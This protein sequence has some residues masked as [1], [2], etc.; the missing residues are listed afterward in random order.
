MILSITTD[1][2]PVTFGLLVLPEVSRVSDT[3]LDRRPDFAVHMNI[4]W[5]CCSIQDPRFSR[6]SCDYRDGLEMDPS[7]LQVA[8]FKSSPLNSKQIEDRPRKSG[9]ILVKKSCIISITVLSI[10]LWITQK[11]MKHQSS[12]TNN[13]HEL[14]RLWYIQSASSCLTYFA[15][16]SEP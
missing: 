7:L 15:K 3:V 2:E 16:V 10:D 14:G 8:K 5:G 12:S 4:Y 9:D 11:P 1:F 13:W 6:S